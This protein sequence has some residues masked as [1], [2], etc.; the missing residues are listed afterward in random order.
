MYVVRYRH[1]VAAWLAMQQAPGLSARLQWLN[2]TCAQS[3]LGLH[4]SNHALSSS[5][6]SRLG[7]SAPYLPH[8][9]SMPDYKLGTLPVEIVLFPSLQPGEQ[10][11]CRHST[12]P[13][14]QPP[15]PA[16]PPPLA[17]VT[18]GVARTNHRPLAASSPQASDAF[19]HAVSKQWAAHLFGPDHLSHLSYRGPRHSRPNTVH[20]SGP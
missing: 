5:P 7:R 8:G 10:T 15:T 4:H 17:S 16:S 11:M 12:P 20:P 6:L 18:L 2:T 13:S 14:P 19:T 9:R 3:H 1:I